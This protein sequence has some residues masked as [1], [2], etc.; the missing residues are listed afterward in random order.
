MMD[1]RLRFE[2]AIRDKL[3]MLILIALGVAMALVAIPTL[4]AG[5]QTEMAQLAGFGVLLKLMLCCA[6]LGLMKLANVLFQK[7]RGRDRK[8][9]IEKIQEDSIATAIYVASN[10]IASALVFGLILSS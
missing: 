7:V 10:G 8:E 9:L 4:T 6:A 3:V 2:K 1:N 5:V